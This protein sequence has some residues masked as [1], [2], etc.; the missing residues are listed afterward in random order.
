MI[1]Y[2]EHCIFRFKEAILEKLGAD[3]HA[4][5]KGVN[6][7]IEHKTKIGEIL[8]DAARHQVSEEDAYKIIEFGMIVR[9]Y[10][11]LPQIPFDGTFKP[12]CLSEPVHR[13]ILTAVDVMLEGSKSFCITGQYK[14][15]FSL[16][17]SPLFHDCI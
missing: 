11:L 14:I 1:I 17:Y 10:A 7:Y 15:R 2:N 12:N 8:A 4:Y 16:N 9:K 13:A 6:V 3:W 5:N